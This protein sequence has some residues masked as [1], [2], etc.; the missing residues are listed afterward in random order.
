MARAAGT[1]QYSG[2]MAQR[3]ILTPNAVTVL[4]QRYLARNERGDVTERPADL[5]RRVAGAVASAET[6]YGLSAGAA[7]T[8]R[9]EFLR[10]MMDGKFMP[11]SPTLMNAGRGHPTLARA[12]LTGVRPRGAR[13]QT[14][15]V[16]P[17]SFSHGLAAGGAAFERSQGGIPRRKPFV[18]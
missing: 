11:N 8:I 12:A 15:G 4:E 3:C 14:R 2:Q 1:G 13:L 9:D 10:I 16:R 6:A 5:F 18:V 7:E 17:L